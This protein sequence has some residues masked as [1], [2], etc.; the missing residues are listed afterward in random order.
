LRGEV[1]SYK[2][3]PTT[4]SAYNRHDSWGSNFIYLS[5]K[6]IIQ[7]QPPSQ[8]YADA[9][10]SLSKVTVK[11]YDIK[12]VTVSH[13]DEGLASELLSNL[14]SD[15]EINKITLTHELFTGSENT[16]KS[17]YLLTKFDF[18]IIAVS[19]DLET[20]KRQK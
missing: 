18:K 14:C 19:D 6:K 11:E 3:D 13:E 2:P 5:Y 10:L 15:A 1:E 7:S 4:S 8:Q 16:S 17:R 20:W 12:A 9:S